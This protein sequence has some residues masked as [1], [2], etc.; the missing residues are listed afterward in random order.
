M[1][2]DRRCMRWCTGLIAAVAAL[3][4]LGGNLL[5]FVPELLCSPTALSAMMYLETGRIVRGVPQE[6]AESLP[7]APKPVETET[8]SLL[9]AE[10]EAVEV[11]YFCDLRPDL[12]EMAAKPLNWDLTDGQPA[13]L[14]LHTHAMESYEKNGEDY[15]ESSPYRTADTRYN[16]VS[17]GDAVAEILEENGIAVIHDRSL[18]DENSYEDAYDDARQTMEEYLARYPTIRLV[19]DLHRDAAERDGVQIVT[20]CMSGEEETAHLMF[21]MGTDAGGYDHPYWQENLS[22]AVKLQAYLSRDYPELFRPL[23]LSAG[24][25]NQDA[26]AGILLVEVGTAGNTHE[27]AVSAA[28]LLAEGIAALSHGTTESGTG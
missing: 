27:Q 18:H 17:I 3:R 12:G 6:T 16:M 11:S 14:I 2:E 13:V 19:L 9:P 23:Q 26:H 4:L 28:R 25:Y 10:G 5:A 21:V 7:T 1:N 8:V 15:E 20:T 24:R 22:L